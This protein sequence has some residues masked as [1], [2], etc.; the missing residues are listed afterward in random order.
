MTY[1]L[2]VPVGSNFVCDG[3][4]THNTSLAEILGWMLICL[5]NPSST[6][7]KNDKESREAIPI[8]PGQAYALVWKVRGG[9][10]FHPNAS[11]GYIAHEFNGKGGWDH[12]G[13][14]GKWFHLM[15]F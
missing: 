1:D 4:I 12:T 11:P 9:F 13:G 6:F 10:R 15:N 14:T 7:Y 5:Y 2:H 3:F 8:R